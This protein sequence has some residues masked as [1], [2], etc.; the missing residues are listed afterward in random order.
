MSPEAYVETQPQAEEVPL[1]GGDVTEGVVRKGDTVRR[2]LGPHSPA[3]HA[4]LRHLESVGFDGAPRYLG[5]D[6][7]GR[8]VLTYVE[9][10]VAGR[11]WPAW[12]SEESRLV[13]LA[14]LVR[15]LDDALLG[16]GVP[17]GLAPPADLPAGMPDPLGPPPVLLGHVDIT[18]ENVVWRAGRAQALIDFDLLRPCSRLE[19]VLSVLLWWA[20]LMPPEDRP[21][22]MRGVDA[23][24]RARLVV[25]AYGLDADSRTQLVRVAVRAAERSWHTMRHRA[26]VRGGG[27]ARMWDDGVGERIR[28]R[29]AWLEACAAEL[30]RAVTG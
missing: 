6:A 25:D 29:Q 15:R 7:A 2:P 8:E 30:H 19:E 3:V 14:R 5:V 23:A 4:V 10:E 18:P 17:A 26:I 24:A 21:D 22:A 20:P 13:S 27:W 9:G 1:A 11:P 12:V 28:R 16:L